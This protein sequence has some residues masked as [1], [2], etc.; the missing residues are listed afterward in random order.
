[1]IA[2]VRINAKDYPE[3]FNPQY[4][5]S[6][7]E[8]LRQR[9]ARACDEYIGGN[10]IRGR[11]Y[12][13]NHIDEIV[14]KLFYHSINQRG[15]FHVRSKFNRRKRKRLRVGEFKEFVWW[16]LMLRGYSEMGL[17][18]DVNAYE[19]FQNLMKERKHERV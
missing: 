4:E 8:V 14:R 1:M 2:S 15:T 19:I 16:K 12:F 7:Y 13:I 6:D 11:D 10:N 17:P 18:Y 3:V 5:G 9:I